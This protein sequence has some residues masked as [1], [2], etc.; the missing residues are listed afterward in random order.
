MNIVLIDDEPIIHQSLTPFLERSGHC[1]RSANDGIEGLA[2]I[3][4]NEPDLV[5]SDVKMPRMD[6]LELLATLHARNPTLPV[7]LI[8]GH[9][10]AATTTSALDNGAFAH[11]RKPV[12]LD[13]L[14]R[15]VSRVAERQQLESDLLQATQRLSHISPEQAAAITQ[16]GLAQNVRSANDALRNDLDRFQRL[17]LQTE[18][19]LRKHL[20]REVA[21][22]ELL[23][24]M[25]EIMSALDKS[26][27]RI[28]EAV[29]PQ[30]PQ[31]S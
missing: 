10:D 6:G 26:S 11:L 30:R 12:K 15:V 18:P 3:A 27:Q 4:D 9:S 24:A 1:V 17:W 8:T 14:T 29:N 21:I 19:A 25:P 5:V 31:A 28:V 22:A 13:E 23:A 7:V 2:L 20:E 16:E